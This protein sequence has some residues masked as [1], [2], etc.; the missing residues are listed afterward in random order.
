[1]LDFMESLRSTNGDYLKKY[2]GDRTLYCIFGHI[3]A[4]CLTE[5]RLYEADEVRYAGQELEPMDDLDSPPK[6]KDIRGPLIDEL[7]KEI[8]K[9]FPPEGIEAFKVFDVNHFPN[10]PE[11]FPTYGLKEVKKVAETLGYRPGRVTQIVTEWVGLMKALATDQSMCQRPITKLDSGMFWSSLLEEGVL[12]T[13][14]VLN[15]FIKHLL[16]IPTG[17]AEAERDQIFILKLC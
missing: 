14:S 5:E 15:G 17:S 10:L 1:M 7:K 4:Q 13:D 12:P 16:S 9:L 3:P 11:H 2:L 6:L 8:E